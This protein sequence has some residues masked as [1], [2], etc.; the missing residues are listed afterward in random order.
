MA[1]A[2]TVHIPEETSSPT[3][4]RPLQLH[5]EKQ[6]ITLTELQAGFSSATY[7]PLKGATLKKRKLLDR[8]HRRGDDDDIEKPS[9]TTTEDAY[10]IA[11]D[12]DGEISRTRGSASSRLVFSAAYRSSTPPPLMPDLDGVLALKQG[13]LDSLFEGKVT[14]EVLSERVDDLMKVSNPVPTLNRYIFTAY[15][16]LRTAFMYTGTI[17]QDINDRHYFRDYVVELLRGALSVHSIPYMRGEIYVPAVS[18]RKANDADATG[19]GKFAD[20][21]SESEGQQILLSERSKL[22]RAPASKDQDFKLKLKRMLRDLFIFTI[23]EMTKNKDRVKPN[24]KIFGS[25]TLK[26][27]TE[28][29]A[30]DSWNLQDILP[31]VVQNC[32]DG[33]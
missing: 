4:I 16:P 11:D 12:D 9:M 31:R 8:K 19:R 1:A 28:L 33:E 10:Y 6:T 25:R 26:N 2:A 20:G 17:S 15:Q 30:I 24:L 7:S 13:L 14:L 27:T 22:H 23:L 5:A 32:V 3:F 18:Y 21:V 29:I